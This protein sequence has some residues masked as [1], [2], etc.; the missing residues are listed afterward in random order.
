MSSANQKYNFSG[1][2]AL[3]TGS[4]SGIGAAIAEQFA[5][6]GA[7]VTIT[8]RDAK[9]LSEVAERIQQVSNGVKPLQLVGDLRDDEHFPK[10][11]IDETIA[12]YGRLDFL[13]NNAGGTTEAATLAHPN[14]LDAFDKVLRLNLRVP[15][16]LTQLAVPHLEKTKGNIINISSVAGIIPMQLVYSTSKAALDM[17]TKTS[18]LELGPK[19]IRVN[20]LNPGPVVT[21]FGRSR[22]WTQ[23][24]MDTFYPTLEK[25][26][27]LQYIGRPVDIANL[28]SFLASDDARNIN[29]AIYVSDS[30]MIIYPPKINPQTLTLTADK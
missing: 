16:E 13:I 11:L 3:V 23:E 29:G 2:V 10:K 24:Y 28:A 7:R 5:Q 1:R 8:G 14:M 18:A 27:L 30:G 20:S 6:Y 9:T 17:V 22:G 15:V 26:S 19:G 21:P 12:A 25:Q 4:S